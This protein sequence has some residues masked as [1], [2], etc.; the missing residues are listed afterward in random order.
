M[1]VAP[2]IFDSGKNSLQL[3]YSASKGLLDGA[4]MVGNGYRSLPSHMSL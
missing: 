2:T 4:R 3:V 1:F